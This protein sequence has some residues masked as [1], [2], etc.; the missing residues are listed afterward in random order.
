MQEIFGY[1]TFALLPLP[2]KKKKKKNCVQVPHGVL[3][4]LLFK[5]KSCDLR[6]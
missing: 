2:P 4:R 1:L 5:K 6:H 3:E